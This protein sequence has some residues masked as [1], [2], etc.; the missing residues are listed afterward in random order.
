MKPFA[1]IGLLVPIV[2]GGW[3]L[4]SLKSPAVDE[5]DDVQIQVGSD[6]VSEVDASPETTERL[7]ETTPAEDQV[8]VYDGISVSRNAT[9]LDLSG[10]GLSGSL[11]AEIRQLSELRELDISNNKF[12]GLPAEVGQLSKLERLDLS[13]N[14]LTGLP[15]ELGNLHDLQMLDLRGTQYSKYDLDIIK[16][17]LPLSVQ[18]LTD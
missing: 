8:V 6:A 17:G 11:K 15:H 12:T 3:W 10:K 5:G 9:K 7:F 4:Y 16:S 14:P 2:A 13:N 1:L 18:I